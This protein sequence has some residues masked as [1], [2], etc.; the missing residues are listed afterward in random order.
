VT[1]YLNTHMLNADPPDH[2][3]LRKLVSRAFTPRRVAGL[4]P[5]VEAIAG[6]LLDA[7]EPR[8]TAGDTVDLIEAFAFPLPVTVI[9]ELLG[10]PAR[11]RAQFR[12]WSNAIV[13]SEG[14]PGGFRAAGEAMYRRG[15]DPGPRVGAVRHV[16][17][18]PRPGQ[19]RRPRPARRRAGRGR[20]RGLRARDP[21]LPR[22][23][24]GPA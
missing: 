20:A 15:D 10:V 8:L 13:A 12:Q 3:R 1:A 14:E 24:A 19:V 17:G 4:R 9:C 5:R 16:V 21:L 7:V 2:T 18:E 22:R 23:A 11:D 6:T